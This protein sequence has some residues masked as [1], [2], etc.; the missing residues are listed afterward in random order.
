MVQAERQ[1]QPLTGTEQEGTGAGVGDERSDAVDA[2][3]KPGPD[4]G[5]HQTDHP[6][7]DGGDDGHEAGAAEEGERIGHLV[8]VETGVQFGDDHPDYDGPRMPV[9]M[10]LMPR[11]DFTP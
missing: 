3:G 4:Q 7:H 11:M 1:Q 9:S 5:H 2:G 8:G 6:Q 10:E